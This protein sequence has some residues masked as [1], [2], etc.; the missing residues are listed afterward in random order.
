[1]KSP[2]LAAFLAT[3]AAMAAAQPWIPSDCK[4]QHE[5]RRNEFARKM[6]QAQPGSQIYAPKPFPKN[7]A[8]VIEDF[9]YGYGLM[10]KGMPPEQ[11]P[12]EDWPLYAGLQKKTLSFRI[13]R[14][15][16]WAPDRCSP[17]QQRDFYYLLHITDAGQEV[18][19]AIVNQSGLLGGW[20][21]PPDAPE[22]QVAPGRALAA[23][24]LEEALSQVRARFGIKGSRAQYVTTWGTPQ[25]ALP[26][27]CVAFQAGG[28][29]YLF[30]NGELAE[31]TLRGYS[32][33]Q[34]EATRTRRFEI[35]SAVDT[36]KE[37]LVSLADDRW[38][39]A[40]R[41]QPARQADSHP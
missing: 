6:R 14:V 22:L 10:Y 39:L 27:P 40:T 36:E 37:W 28:K 32:R 11:I 33:A 34:M 8:E 1:M 17:D 16:N 29:S 30:L 3:W 9:K 7:D 20:G 18:A 15:E 31:L 21:P 38:V 5:G 41:L 35:S 19:R 26:L 12:Q 24:G 23:P 13:V 2:V 25:C 4:A